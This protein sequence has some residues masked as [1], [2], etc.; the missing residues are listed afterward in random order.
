MPNFS[1]IYCFWVL[2]PNNVYAAINGLGDKSKEPVYAL[3]TTYHI[4]QTNGTTISRV[5]TDPATKIVRLF[6]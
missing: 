1:H 5:L 3:Q 4:S 2:W 6:T